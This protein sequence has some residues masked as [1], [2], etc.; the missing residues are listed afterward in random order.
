VYL[1]TRNASGAWSLAG[2]LPAGRSPTTLSADART[3]VA[4]DPDFN[5]GDGRALVMG[6]PQAAAVSV[7][8]AAGSGVAEIFSFTFSDAGGW[9]NLKV[10]NVLINSRLDARQACYVGLVPTSANSG[11]VILD[12]GRM[13]LPVAGYGGLGNSQCEVRSPG[14]S[15]F[16]SGNTITVNLSIAFQPAFAGYRT[17]Y[18]A[19]QD[20]AGSS[21]WQP[22][23]TW[24][25]TGVM[26]G[27]APGGV[28]PARSN[29]ATQTF[30][31]TFTDSNG[32]QDLQVTNILFRDAL[33]GSH[34]CYMA[35][36][37]TTRSSGALYLVDDAGN[38][39]GPYQGMLL[40]STAS[41]ANSQCSVAGTGSSVSLNDNAMTLTLAITF[42]HS[43]AGNQIIYAAARGATA[44]SGWQPVGTVT[45]P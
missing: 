8:P 10:M 1:F 36:V 12:N 29:A 33:D 9:Q 23:G 37:P 11:F 4:G 20:A 44:N 34:A 14:S 18:L 13:E 16:A 6:V 24:N 5:N 39:A 38:A 15:F 45:V 22:L 26:A 41:I 27:P 7:S 42:S 30:T 25:V 2:T 28:T 21:G 32:V 3:A 40:P 31:F 17:I 43:F 35:F 19:A